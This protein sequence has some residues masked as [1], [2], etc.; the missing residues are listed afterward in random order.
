MTDIT[1]NTAPAAADAS[2]FYNRTEFQA[3]MANPDY[4]TSAR[5]RSDIAAKLQRSQDA[6]TVG[7]LTG[8]HTQEVRSRTVEAQTAPEGTYGQVQDLTK[9]YNPLNMNVA[10]AFSGIE[11]I[12]QAIDAP[13]FDIDPTYRAAVVN[14]ISRSI[15]AGHLDEAALTQLAVWLAEAEAAS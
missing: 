8:H 11:E 9:P 2:I 14:R 7:S 13:G 3:A 5:V 12:G 6:G 1:T 10:A 4:S 15:R